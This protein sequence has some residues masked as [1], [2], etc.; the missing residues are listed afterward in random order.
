MSV[1]AI[2][3]ILYPN[4]ANNV[5]IIKKLAIRENFAK[6]AILFIKVIGKTIHSAKAK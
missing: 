3:S 2:N 1:V 4:M 5:T 6:A